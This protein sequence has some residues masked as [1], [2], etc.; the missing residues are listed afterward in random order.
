MNSLSWVIEEDPLNGGA[1]IFE[2]PYKDMRDLTDDEWD[3]VVFKDQGE[4]RLRLPTHRFNEAHKFITIPE[5]AIQRD[6]V[7]KIYDFYQSEI[8]KNEILNYPNDCLGFV[9][10]AKEEI[11]NG[12]KL[13]WIEI[14]GDLQFFE[15]FH[16][17]KGNLWEM[18]L[19]S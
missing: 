12:K 9:E 18:Y 5:G 10:W 4:I 6:V 14:M 7:R 11:S 1:K 19:G 17:I 13:K 2:D 8:D 15:G 16:H 3:K